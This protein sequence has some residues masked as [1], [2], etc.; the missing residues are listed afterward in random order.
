MRRTKFATSGGGRCRR[1][2]KGLTESMAFHMRVVTVG[3]AGG[4]SVEDD[5][6][7]EEFFRDA[8]LELSDDMICASISMLPRDRRDGCDARDEDREDV[9]L[10]IASSPSPMGWYLT[11]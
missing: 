5:C 1:L 6:W 11:A 3:G 10:G 8:R 9:R 7:E 2:A 4:L